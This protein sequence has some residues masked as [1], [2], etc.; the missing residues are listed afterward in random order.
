[1]AEREVSAFVS[2]HVGKLETVRNKQRSAN[3]CRRRQVVVAAAKGPGFFGKIRESI[4]KPIVAVPGSQGTGALYDCVFCEASGFQKCDGCQ[5]SGTD[6][7][8][9]CLM[10]NGKGSLKCTVCK[11]VGV[12]D[13]IRRGGTDDK[14]EYL[15]KK[16]FLR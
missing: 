7:L 13:R 5:G 11:G 14:N 9:K 2:T 16:K 6:S 4:L 3:Q 8:G 12:V 10:C 15:A 1:M